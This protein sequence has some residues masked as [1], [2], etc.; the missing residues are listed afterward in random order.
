MAGH[1][2]ETPHLTVGG[3]LNRYKVEVSKANKGRRWEEIHLDA[4]QRDRL[5]QKRRL[6]AV[7]ETS[8]RR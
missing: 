8:V 6:E 1:Q 7:S 3:L 2:G 4:L 5:G